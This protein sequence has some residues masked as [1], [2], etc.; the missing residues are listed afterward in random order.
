MVLAAAFCGDGG[1]F[2]RLPNLPRQF[3]RSKGRSIGR[4]AK[5]R[6]RQK[7]KQKHALAAGSKRQEAR[8]QNNKS[9]LIALLP[10][11]FSST[12][13]IFNN[14]LRFTTSLSVIWIPAFPRK[15]VHFYRICTRRRLLTFYVTAQLGFGCPSRHDKER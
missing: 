14:L 2:R 9:G 15:S 11:I 10:L 8:S 1:F 13:V 4:R 6:S 12:I 5:Q 7:Q 3:R